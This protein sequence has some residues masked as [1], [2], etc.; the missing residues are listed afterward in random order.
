M[1][2]HS[3]FLYQFF[4][5]KDVTGTMQSKSEGNKIF[6]KI[7]YGE[8]IR[9]CLNSVLEKY[10][11]SSGE[12]EWGLG[13]AKNLEIGY[14]TG[15]EYIRKTYEGPLEMVVFHGSIASVE[16]R[17]HIHCSGAGADHI[18]VGGHFFSGTAIPL[19][20]ISITKF[21]QINIVREKSQKSG[22]MEATLL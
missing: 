15:T 14:Y 11:I 7:E 3:L 19:M 4:I 20:E 5:H 16:P 6:L 9:D 2:I 17:F 1:Y 22:L 18:M 10:H 12:I 21:D 13:A 8:D